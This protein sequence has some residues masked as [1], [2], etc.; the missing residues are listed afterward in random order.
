MKDSNTHLILLNGSFIIK[1]DI[2]TV[3]S[4]LPSGCSNCGIRMYLKNHESIMPTSNSNP[5][6]FAEEQQLS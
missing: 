2:E 3:L 6:P 5:H 1:K 4:T